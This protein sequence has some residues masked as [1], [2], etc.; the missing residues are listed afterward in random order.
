MPTRTINPTRKRVWD[1]AEQLSTPSALGELLNTIMLGLI[2]L[3]AVA[4]VLESVES[5]AARFHV[6][7]RVFEWVSVMVF[8]FEYVMRL[9]ACVEDERFRHPFFGRI[10]YAL[11]PMA[12]IDLLAILPFYFSTA[13]LDLRFLRVLRLFRVL[14]IVKIGRYSDSARILVGVLRR[15]SADLVLAL[16]VLCFVLFLAASLMYFAEGDVQPQAFPNIPAAMWWAIVTLTTVGYGDIY[17]VTLAG[18]FIAAGV[19]VIGILMFAL[20]TAI[21]GSAFLEELK[22]RER[23]GSRKCN[24]CGRDVAE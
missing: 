8:S 22:G 19:M 3:N 13:G 7:F 10:M 9:W 14:R 23:P 4:V 17:P 1:M 18:K 6:P 12:L 20:P 2:L 16:S 5:Y 11:H 21:L 15:A 24:Y